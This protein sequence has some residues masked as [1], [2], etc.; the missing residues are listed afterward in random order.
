MTN[1]NEAYCPTCLEAV[2]VDYACNFTVKCRNCG[3]EFVPSTLITKAINDNDPVLT[4]PIMP[5]KS[6][7]LFKPLQDERVRRVPLEILCPKCSQ[8]MMFESSIYY[9]FTEGCVIAHI[10]I[11]LRTDL[12]DDEDEGNTSSL[13]D[14]SNL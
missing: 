3:H 11:L 7:E 5:D 2:Y 12:I 10:E 6:W 8:P 9:C 14:A 1:V 4:K 13:L